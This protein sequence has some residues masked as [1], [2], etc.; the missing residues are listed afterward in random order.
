MDALA[1]REG[2]V[3]TG[4]PADLALSPTSVHLARMASAKPGTK[5]L[6]ERRVPGAGERSLVVVVRRGDVYEN[7]VTGE[8]AVVIEGPE[9][10]MERGSSL[11]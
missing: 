2:R 11:L 3:A 9:D 5:R 8:R 6:G 7:P 4:I 1:S 10:T